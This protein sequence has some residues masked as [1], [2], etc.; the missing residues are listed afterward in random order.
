MHDALL[1]ASHVQAR[2]TMQLDQVLGHDCNIVNVQPAA[3]YYVVSCSARAVND[4]PVDY[5]ITR[6]PSLLFHQGSS[7]SSKQ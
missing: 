4:L 5:L 2:L 7:S 6:E 3:G 1:P